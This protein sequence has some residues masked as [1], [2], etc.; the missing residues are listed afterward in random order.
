MAPPG[1]EEAIQ[2]VSQHAGVPDMPAFRRAF[3]LV[4]EVMGKA[5]VRDMLGFYLL[6][7]QLQSLALV[8]MFYQPGQQEM[9]MQHDMPL[10]DRAEGDGYGCRHNEVKRARKPIRYLLQE[11]TKATL[12]CMFVPD[13]NEQVAVGFVS[14][15][16]SHHGRPDPQTESSHARGMTGVRP[17]VH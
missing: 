4:R 6:A 10:Q 11:I 1:L 14:S 17:R 5:F 16:S 12:P 15:F 8:R 13:L 7:K 2:H 3:K 9:L